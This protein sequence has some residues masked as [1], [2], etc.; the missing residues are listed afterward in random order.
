MF[1]DT[2]TVYH[3]ADNK[4]TREV[5]TNVFWDNVKQSNVL[6]SGVVTADSVKIIIPTEEDIEFEGSKD[7]V[8]KGELTYEFDNTSQ[9]TISNSIKHLKD[10]YKDVVTVNV[11]DSKLFGGLSHIQLSCK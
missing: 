1:E 6:K 3:F 11:V 5:I 10:N 9:Q 4:Y 7:I 8:V 2:I